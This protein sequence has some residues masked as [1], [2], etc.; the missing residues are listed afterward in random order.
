[1]K[2]IT[3]LL[4]IIFTFLFSTTSWGEWELGSESVTDGKMYYDK[5]RVRKNGKSLYF[6]ML[7]DYGRP[8]LDGTLSVTTY[9]QLDCS[10][11]R[12]KDLKVQF[13]D[14]GFQFSKGTQY[15]PLVKRFNVFILYTNMMN[16][17]FVDD[18]GGRLDKGVRVSELIMEDLQSERYELLE[19]GTAY[20]ERGTTQQK[21]V[22]SDVVDCG[23]T[24]LAVCEGR[25]PK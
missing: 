16:G 18:T 23:N 12:Y 21:R 9:T 19:R 2:K 3:I 17:D 20:D 8:S 13:Y 11:L 10:I 25:F 5:D 14:G 7:H 1:M 6:W 24:I 22:L 4:F 15:H